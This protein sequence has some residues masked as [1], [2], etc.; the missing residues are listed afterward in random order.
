MDIPTSW[1]SATMSL[2][3]STL[4]IPNN[5]RLNSWYLRSDWYSFSMNFVNGHSYRVSTVYQIQPYTLGNYDMRLVGANLKF[6]SSG[7]YIANYEGRADI[8]SVSQ[9]ISYTDLK[10]NGCSGNYCTWTNTFAFTANRNA[11]SIVLTHGGSNINALNKFMFN[12]D[13]N[14]SSNT[15]EQL[16]ISTLWVSIDDLGGGTDLGPLVSQQ[17]Q[18]NSFLQQI[19]E[20]V[21]EIY[22]FI[23][24]TNYDISDIDDVFSEIS[25]TSHPISGII[26][27]PLNWIDS[28]NGSD[29]PGA[30]CQSL[31]LTMFQHN[32]NIPSGCFFWDRQDVSS[33]RN[34]WNIIFGGFLIYK[35]GYR[36]MKALNDVFDPTKDEIG[37]LEV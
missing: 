28:L 16:K 30:Y 20:K 5:N 15:P 7:K 24:D 34:I 2:G 12:Y 36:L 3:S 35:L 25:T 29:T 9:T 14:Y 21:I 18:T 17:Q 19:K 8:D 22:N 33:F 23:T 32:I 13:G 4:G 1:N 37:G 6:A 31:S 27:A 26:T 11:S 10:Y